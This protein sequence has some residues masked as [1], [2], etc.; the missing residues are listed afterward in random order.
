MRFAYATF[1]NFTFWYGFIWPP[2]RG[3]VW[4]A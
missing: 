1:M 2:A 3:K 4:S